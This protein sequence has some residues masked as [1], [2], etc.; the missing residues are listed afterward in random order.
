MIDSKIMTLLTLANIGNYTKTAKV[1]SLTQPAVSHHIK[2]L[3][4]E[5]GI[6]I[7]YK[8][9]KQLKPTPEGEILI[10]YAKRIVALSDNAMQAIEDSKKSIKRFTVGITTTMGEYLVSQV[11]ATYCKEN[12]KVHINIVTDNI[13]NIY[14]ML[15][16]Y[17]LD[18]AIIEGNISNKKYTSI[19]LDTDYLCLIVSPKHKFAKKKSVSLFELKKEKFI[20]RS[21]NAGTRILFE[22]HLLSHSENIKNFNIV[23]EIDNITAIKELVASNLGVSI[24]AHSAIK[25]EEASGK[26]VVVPIENLNMVREINMVYHHDFK[27]TQVLKDI[28]RIYNLGM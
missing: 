13:K 3:E 9:K 15:Q 23:I 27:H 12:P 4:E 19:L 26:L 17:E 22:N 10:K 28:R 6:K 21:S 1:L 25:E 2:L 18:C 8:N 11:F 14:D 20:L 7:F 5:Y 16:S 24:M